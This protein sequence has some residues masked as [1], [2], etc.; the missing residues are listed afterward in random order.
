MISVQKKRSAVGLS[1]T[2]HATHARACA[3]RPRERRW[4]PGPRSRLPRV[5]RVPARHPRPAPLSPVRLRPLPSR[6]RA[7]PLPLPVPRPFPCPRWLHL[8]IGCLL[9]ECR[10]A[11]SP[12]PAALAALAPLLSVP[13][14][15]PPRPA[16]AALRPAPTSS[17]RATRPRHV[18]APTR[19]RA[20]PHDGAR[21][22]RRR[23]RGRLRA[24]R[25]PGLTAASGEGAGGMEGA[26]AALGA[27]E[28]GGR[29][30]EGLA[31]H[32]AGAGGDRGA[33]GAPGGG[34]RGRGDGLRVHC[35]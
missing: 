2:S 17:P 27:A 7:P 12:L 14:P 19:A 4:P 15:L 21:G 22:A 25:A 9:L 3:P 13:A 30:A 32:G 29:A 35:C 18:H 26:A 5:P 16:A 10:P 28:Q 34:G 33:S 24:L 1:T 20:P 6:L 8:L 11:G 23:R 31:T